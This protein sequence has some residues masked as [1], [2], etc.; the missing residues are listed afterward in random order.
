MTIEV[1]RFL[2]RLM[3]TKRFKVVGATLVELSESLKMCMASSLGHAESDFHKKRKPTVTELNF[4]II[5]IELY[6]VLTGK[7]TFLLVFT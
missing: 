2:S 5:T 7:R 1:K 6:I 4:E 3:E